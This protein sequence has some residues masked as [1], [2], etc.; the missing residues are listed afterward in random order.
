MMC[1]KEKK[2]KFFKT[3]YLFCFLSD[4]EAVYTIEWNGFFSILWYFKKNYV[5]IQFG[6]NFFFKV[7]RFKN[8]F[9][10]FFF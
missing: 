4:V 1:D 8:P 3:L 5:K 7:T 2:K 10:N 9:Y 6:L